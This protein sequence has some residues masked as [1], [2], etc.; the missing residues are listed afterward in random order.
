[1]KKNTIKKALFATSAIGI[2]ILFYQFST[3]DNNRGVDVKNH[4]FLDKKINFSNESVPTHITDVKERLDRE[5]IV[6]INFH[7]NTTLVIKR[8]NRY[9]PIIEPILKKHGIPDDFKYLCVIE[10]S[11]S[12]V[13][14]P[15]GAKGFW[16][17]MPATATEY[18][19]EVSD[20]VDERYHLI[21][22]TEAAADYFNKAYERFGNWTLVAAAFN[23]G[24][25]GIQRQLDLQMVDS[26]YDLFINQETSR[27][28]FRILALKEIM[29]DP[30]KYGFNIPKDARYP[31]IKTKNVSASENI[32]NLYQFAKD[33]GIN[34][35][36]LK[37]HNPWLQSDK[38]EVKTGKTYQIAIPEKP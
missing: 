18:G 1:M 17:F 10:S 3:I 7:S 37:L 26:Y 27:Y 13:T 25:T 22:A 15:A 14:S 35:K 5:M 29:S 8:A 36:L 32:D 19:L 33:Q 11:L 20:T 23:R 4:V 2:G 24:T 9:F 34:Y 31:M 21:K 38:L 12:N 6:N 28:V 30:T 16:Q